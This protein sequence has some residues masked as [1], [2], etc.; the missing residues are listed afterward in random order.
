V[1]VAVIAVRV[2]EVT[3]DEV[4]D[5]IPVRDGLVTAA[6]AVHVVGRVRA[7]GVRR[8]ARRVRGVDLERVLFHAGVARVVQVTVVHV[9]DVIPVLHRG[10]TAA[11]AVNVVVIVVRVAHGAAPSGSDSFGLVRGI[12][13]W[14]CRA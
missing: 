11:G 5:V 8:T 14:S 12:V 9:V 13:Q 2:V 7:A 4:V 10:V 6:G 1:I 3:V